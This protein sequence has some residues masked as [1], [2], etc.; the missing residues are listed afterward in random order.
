MSG[1]GAAAT[2]RPLRIL[3]VTPRYAPLVGG[4]ET[5]TAEVAK[6]LAAG[7][8]E[9]TVLTTD[10]GGRL[11]GAQTIEGVSIRRVRAWPAA[12]DLYVAPG[13]YRAIAQHPGRWDLVHCQGYHTFV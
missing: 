8:A 12:L 3:F 2:E 9:V 10:P 1:T 7:G 4:V 11:P 13:I 5:H 6:R